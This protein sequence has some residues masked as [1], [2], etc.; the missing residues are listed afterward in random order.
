MK[1]Y[2]VMLN[3]CS[4]GIVPLVVGDEHEELATFDTEDEAVA[5]GK[6]NTLG[7]HFGFEVFC[8]GCGEITG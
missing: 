1:P 8:T 2:F 5:A 4:G 7:H 3:C 6:D